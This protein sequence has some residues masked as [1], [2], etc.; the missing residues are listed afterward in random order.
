MVVSPVMRTSLASFA[1]LAIASCGL[2]GSPGTVSAQSEPS[3]PARP[4]IAASEHPLDPALAVARDSLQHI[5]TNILDY[6]AIM[7][8]RCRVDGRLSDY[9]QAF[10]KIR[11]RRADHDR[12]SVPLSVYMKFRHPDAIRGR[13]VI[14]VE[15]RNGGKLVAHDTGIK[16]LIRVSLDPHGAMAMRGQRYPIMEIGLENLAKKMLEK[17]ERDRQHGECFVTFS[18]NARVA[19]RPCVVFQIDHPVKRSHFEFFRAQ[20]FFDDELKMPIRYASWSWPND[21]EG[22]PVLEEEYTYTDIRVN[23][24]DLLAHCLGL[25]NRA[26]HE[27]A[28]YPAARR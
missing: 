24:G 3:G 7:T 12:L 17:G 27:K 18:R 22:H 14:W 23:V 8:K 13:E 2:A 1:R 28:F 10:V 4:D 15:G 6:T 9:Q 5:Q 16:G 11:N 19:E 26:W 25:V 21:E 20:V